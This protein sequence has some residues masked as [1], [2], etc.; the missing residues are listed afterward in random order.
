[1]NSLVYLTIG[2][3]LYTYRVTGV[4]IRLPT[5]PLLYA[6]TSN[7]QTLSLVACHPPNS[8]KYRLVVHAVIIDI[9]EY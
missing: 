1:V 7:D 8:V 6:S 2:T 9:A 3:K 5:D 4:D